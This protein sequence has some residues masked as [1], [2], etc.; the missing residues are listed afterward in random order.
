METDEIFTDQ[1]TILISSDK[2]HISTV[3][4]DTILCQTNQGIAQMIVDI[5]FQVE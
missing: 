1:H 5:N 3:E 2:H 4:P